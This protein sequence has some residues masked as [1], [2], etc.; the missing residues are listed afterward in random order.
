MSAYS[1]RRGAG[2]GRDF[3]EA[4]RSAYNRFKC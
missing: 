1:A 4:I 2:E 3:P